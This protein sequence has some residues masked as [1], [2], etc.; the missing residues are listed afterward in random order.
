MTAHSLYALAQAG[1]TAKGNPQT[2]TLSSLRRRARNAGYRAK[3][4]P[5]GLNRTGLGEYAIIDCQFN[6]LI[7]TA[8]DDDD[9]RGWLIHLLEDR[10]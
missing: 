5:L 7:G 8:N 10:E 9:L 6:S 1:Y 3:W 2:I 4:M